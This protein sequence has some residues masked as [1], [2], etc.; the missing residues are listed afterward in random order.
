[1]SSRHVSPVTHSFAQLA[2]GNCKSDSILALSSKNERLTTLSETRSSSHDTRSQIA[3][4]RGFVS[5]FNCNTNQPETTAGARSE[6]GVRSIGPSRGRQCA[7]WTRCCAMTLAYFLYQSCELLTTFGR[8]LIVTC[9][10]PRFLLGG[11]DSARAD[12]L[13]SCQDTGLLSGSRTSR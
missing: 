13:A 11:R 2:A 6:T 4:Q 1:M 3:L 9:A 8:F 12:A 7:R 10:N 5:E